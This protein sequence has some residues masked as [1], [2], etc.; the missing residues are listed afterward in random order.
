MG[1]VKLYDVGNGKK[2][3]VPENDKV[4]L[5]DVLREYLSPGAVAAISALLF[6]PIGGYTNKDSINNEIKWFRDYLISIVGIDE[7]NNC[8]EA[9]GM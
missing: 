9:L 1:K 2:V 4:E 6:E 5:S 7:V 3:T 8:I